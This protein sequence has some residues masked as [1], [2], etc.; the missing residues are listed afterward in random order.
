MIKMEISTIQPVPNEP[1]LYII[2]KKILVFADLHI[3]IESQLR[4]QGVITKSR[5]E[6]MINKLFSICKKFK[7]DH[8]ILLGDIKHNIPTST[9]QERKDV[10]NFLRLI[11]EYGK[12]HIIPGNHDGNIKWLTSESIIIHP[13]SGFV[14]N[15]I[16]F[17]H[18]H[19]WPNEEIM[20]C[21]QI[22]L[23]HTHPTVMF[24]DRLNFKTFEPCWVKGKFISK[25]LKEKYP[26]SINPSFLIMPA[27]N[28]LCG[29]AAVNHDGIVGPMGKIIDIKNSEIYLID[30]VSLGK[31]KDLI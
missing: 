1:A 31:V 2:E 12:I 28:P 11:E 10:K 26:E 3:G 16:G 22:I 14:F 30:G 23:A 20:K 9:I 6:I 18:G 4:E 25:K 8:I 24:L 21:K 5:S 7:P 29:G 27:F 15:E 13:S 17:I 19:R